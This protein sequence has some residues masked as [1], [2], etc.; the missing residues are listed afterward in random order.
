MFART[1]G[2]TAPD[3]LERVPDPPRT[4]TPGR[5]A[6]PGRQGEVDPPREVPGAA[7][8]GSRGDE[9]AGTLPLRLPG[10]RVR[11]DRGPVATGAGDEQAGP[12]LP[13]CLPLRRQ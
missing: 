1:F 5:T 8:G 9:R 3:G 7:R 4:P 2:N 10:D 11:A 6:P 13:A 12:R